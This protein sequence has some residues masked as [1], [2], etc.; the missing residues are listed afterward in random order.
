MFLIN[1][2]RYFGFS[3]SLFD[4][5]NKSNILEASRCRGIYIVKV[6][7]TEQEKKILI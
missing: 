3:F 5:I 4:K 2:K 1:M 6:T 7:S